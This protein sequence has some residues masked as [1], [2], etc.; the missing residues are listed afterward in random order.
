MATTAPNTVDRLTEQRRGLPDEPGVYLFRDARGR[1]VYVGK[2]KS[3]RKR[4]AS[5]FSTPTR[6]GSTALKDEVDHIEYI[7]VHTESEAL[8]TEQNFIRQYK[9]RFNIRLRDDKSYPYIAISLDEDYPR[10][11]FTRERHRRDRAYFGPYSSAKRVRGTLDLLGKIFQFRSCE[12]AEPGRH[13]GSPCLDYHIKRCGAPCVG[14][15]S[16]A[17]YREGIDGV[18]AFLSGRFKQIERDLERR[19]FFHAGEQ[20][21]EQ[22]ALQRNKLQAV[23]ALLE[24]QRVATEGAGTFDAVAVAV[25]GREANA[26]VF[27]VRDDVLSDRQSFYLDNEGEQPA[28]LVAEEFLLQ[29][30]ASA[31]AIPSLIVVQQ[32][33]AAESEPDVLAQMLAERRGASVEIRPAERGAKWRILE[34]A[35]RNARLALDQ[36]KLRAERK[37]QQRVDGLEGLQTALRLDAL[38]VRVECFDISHM[39]G[40]HTTASMVVFEGGAPKKSDYR[41]FNVRDVEPGDDYGAMS[42]VL[43]R[44]FQQWE[45]Q[46]ERS[47]Y[48][49]DRDASF[50]ALP[51]LIVIDGG[52]G[53]LAA[54]LGPLEGFRERGVAVVS[55]A[56]RIEEVFRPGNPVP[57]LLPHDTPELQLLQRIRDEAHRFAITH[58]RLRRDKAMTES[59]MDELPGI[60]PN[61]KRALLQRFGSPEAVLGAT[62]EE[63][64]SV[65]GVPAKVARDLYAHLNRTGR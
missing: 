20:D 24:R 11:Y 45:R 65:P 33:L 16:K 57:V 58:H 21:Y 54:G 31:M 23:K 62:R 1:V 35:E 64:E 26:Q 14:Y 19:M 18:M 8:L 53:Q 49:A 7:V 17:E 60:G 30:Y 37:R 44:R 4:V 25:D 51:N 63:L 15:V 48:D 59:I 2:A 3:I 13:S 29:F 38:P 50:G 47:P 40:T 6:Y 41:R 43:T 52:K 22:A 12:G 10:V 39:G 55:L 42:E 34:L 5:H 36:E 32:D 27:Q 56:K 9:P 61:R 28:A 46:A